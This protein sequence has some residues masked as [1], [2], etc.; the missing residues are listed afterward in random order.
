[1]VVLSVDLTIALSIAAARLMG[2]RAQLGVLTGG[3]TA[4]CGVS[5]ALALSAALL[6]HPS[7]IAP[8]SSQ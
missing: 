2:F 8:R 1:M 5:A 7:K 6:S 4:I 3:A